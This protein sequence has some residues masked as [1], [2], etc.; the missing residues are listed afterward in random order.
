MFA[1]GLRFQNKVDFVEYFLQKL[2]YFATKPESVIKVIYEML[3]SKKT[4]IS[5]LIRCLN[6]YSNIPITCENFM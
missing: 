4:S 6:S 5:T 1:F 3:E 2:D